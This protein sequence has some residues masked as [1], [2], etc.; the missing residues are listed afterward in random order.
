LTRVFDTATGRT[1]AKTDQ[2]PTS[3]TLTGMVGGEK[4]TFEYKVLF[5]SETNRDKA[6]VEDLWARRKVG[7]LLDQIRVNGENKE[8]KDEV[9]LLAKKYGITTP[10]TSYLVVPDGNGRVAVDSK[11]AGGWSN[12]YKNHGYQIDANRTQFA[13]IFAP[14]GMPAL[15]TSGPVTA[16]P[17]PASAPPYVGEVIIQGSTVTQDRVIRR[18]P[19]PTSGGPLTY[20]TAQSGKE[21]VDLALQ[22]NEMRNQDRVARATA[23]QAAGRKCLDINGVWTDDGV[24]AK[25]PLVKLK[26]QSDAYFRMLERH[27]HMREVF[28]LGNRVVWVTPSRSVLVIEPAAGEERMSDA[29]IDRLFVAKK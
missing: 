8:L 4:Q 27:P 26:A 6:F 16:S 7:Y 24:D 19:A 5:A 17:L 22:L 2:G 13:P 18:A 25:M 15:P 28:Q 23:K 9:V 1:P 12:Y 10:Y 29:D 14:P 21:G 3:V 11:P 20:P